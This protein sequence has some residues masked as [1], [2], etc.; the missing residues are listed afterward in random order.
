MNPKRKVG[1]REGLS[2]KERI[3]KPKSKFTK[4]RAVES[5]SGCGAVSSNCKNK[6]EIQTEEQWH[7]KSWMLKHRVPNV[8]WRRGGP[9]PWV[10]VVPSKFVSDTASLPSPQP[11]IQILLQCTTRC[12][13]GLQ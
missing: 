4:F 13:T 2:L 10:S 1:E 12:Q 7:P 9:M 6:S 5:Q 3:R 8:G 11:N